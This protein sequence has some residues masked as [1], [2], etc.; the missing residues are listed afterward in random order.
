[1]QSG[2]HFQY[3]VILFQVM[4]PKPVTQNAKSFEAADAVFHHDAFARL[5]FVAEFLVGGPFLSSG[6]FVR[7]KQLGARVDRSKPLKTRIHSNGQSLKPV[8]V[9]RKCFFE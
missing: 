4:H 2:T 8:L 1:M 5:L 3:F 6:L 7:H 9:R